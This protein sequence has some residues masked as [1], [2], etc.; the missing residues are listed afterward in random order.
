MPKSAS[1]NLDSHAELQK[2]RKENEQLR[3]EREILQGA[4]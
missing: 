4:L 1:I 2:L 3:M